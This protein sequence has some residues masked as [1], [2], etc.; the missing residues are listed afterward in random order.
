MALAVAFLALLTTPLSDAIG[1]SQVALQVACGAG[2]LFTLFHVVRLVIRARTQNL[3]QATGSNVLI[4][5][6][7]ALILVV[8]AAGLA[9]GTATVYEWF[10]VLMLAR[11]ALAFVFV[12]SEVTAG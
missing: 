1:N 10:L 4:F 6:I 9:M 12:L 5:V 7:N 2:L 8:G 3:S 11:P